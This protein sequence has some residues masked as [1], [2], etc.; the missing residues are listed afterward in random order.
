VLLRN[1]AGQPTW[2]IVDQPTAVATA[3]PAN[4]ASPT[5]SPLPTAIPLATPIG[6]CV[7]LQVLPVIGD[8]LSA[9]GLDWGWYRA[10][11]DGVLPNYQNYAANTLGYAEH[12][13]YILP[14]PTFTPTPTGTVPTATPTPTGTIVPSPTPKPYFLAA[15]QTPS[16]LPVVSFIRPGT[17]DSQHPGSDDVSRGEVFVAATLVPAIM[18]STPYQ[19]NKVAIVITYDENGGRWD[20]VAPPNPRTPAA[21]PGKTDQF[22][23]GSRVPA[24]V[25]A[26]WAKR[27]FVDHTGYDT[28]SIAAFIER[29]WGLRPLSTRDAAADPLHNAFNFTATPLPAGACGDTPIPAPTASGTRTPPSPPAATPGRLTPAQAIA[30]VRQTYG[31][32]GQ[33]GVPA[34]SQVGD[35]V[36]VVG[37]VAGSGRVTSSMAWTLTAPVPTV[38][39]TGTVAQAVLSTTVG[40]EAF[41]C[42]PVV[43]GAAIATCAGTTGGNALQGSAVVVVFA[44]GVTAVGTVT[45][46]GGAGA[47]AVPVAVVPSAPRVPPPLLPPLMPPPGPLALAPPPPPALLPPGSPEAPPAVE[48]PL[49]P[50]AESLLLVALGLAVLALLGR[51]RGRAP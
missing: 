12:M 34:A 50:E 33:A 5:A 42:T 36:S 27:C 9:A 20:H 22:G 29:N 1:G 16:A 46:P 15:V 25:I 28:T 2:Y 4:L 43:A 35:V 30:Q 37:P 14:S 47:A 31:Q 32:S 11:I 38:V 40:L 49:I 6:T 48:V 41:A 45:G 21:T 3:C 24:I 51:P 18:T 8:R 26:P 7:P 44:P 39:A 17:G 23:P 13:R 10:D 19:Q